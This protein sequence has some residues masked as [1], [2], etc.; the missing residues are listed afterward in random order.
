MQAIV[1]S[2]IRTSLKPS[3]VIFLVSSSV[4]SDYKGK[5]CAHRKKLEYNVQSYFSLVS[6]YIISNRDK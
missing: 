3:D 2:K 6:L 4:I 1:K 5:L